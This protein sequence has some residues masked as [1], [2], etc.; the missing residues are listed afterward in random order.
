MN[1]KINYKAKLDRIFSQYIRLRDRLPNSE[2]VKCISCGKIIHWK[3]SDCGHYVTRN[4]LGLRYNEQNCNAQ[5][6]KCN[7]FDEA[8]KTG[9]TLG[10]IQKYGKNII[11]IL[12]AAKNKHIKIT[13]FEYEALIQHYTN[14]VKKLENINSN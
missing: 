2:V 8:N 9:Y 12:H 11:E 14:E 4:V 7:R 13:Q 10:L 5:C 6:R 1:K 3:E